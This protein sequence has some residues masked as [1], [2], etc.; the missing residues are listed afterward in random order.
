M[1]IRS[2]TVRNLKLLAD[3]TF[4]FEREDGGTRSW[5]VLLGDNG[6]CKTTVLQAI[7]IA[8][9]GDK[10]ARALGVEDAADYVN[11]SVP[12]GGASIDAVFETLH[13]DVT[14]SMRVEPG[15]HAFKGGDSFFNDVRDARKGGYLVVGYG[16]GRRLP[17]PGE[18]AISRDPVTDRVEGLF[19]THH[20][21]LGVDFFDALRQRDPTLGLRFAE[22]LGKVLRHEDGLGNRL[23][24]WLSSFERRGKGGVQEMAT[25][26]ESRRMVLDVGRN[27]PIKLAPHQL[28]QGY[29]STFAWIADLLGHAF[30]DAGGAVEP[31]EMRGIVLL[32]EIDLHLHPTWQRRLV[33]LL[34]SLFPRVQFVVTTHSPLVLTGF[35]AEEIIKLDL[36]EGY[37][38]QQRFEREP[39]M[40]TSTE[41]TAAYFDVPTAARP[42]LVARQG[43]LA[44]LRVADTNLTAEEADERAA[45]EKQ[46]DPYLR[47]TSLADPSAPPGRPIAVN[48]GCEHQMRARA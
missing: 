43:R 6:V 48:Q 42:E 4:S 26:L 19:D 30:L 37:V 18:V 20:K 31:S 27:D 16:I 5:T 8:S 47:A 9:A 23:L 2:L 25:L 28:S 41:L 32:D 1:R 22:T 34:R 7:A 40:Q 11:A 10:W 39:G 45:L 15:E 46:L 33:P 24:P 12:D 14:V 38:V 17:K 44:E 36:R 21:M 3:Q 13:G 35:E 29:Q